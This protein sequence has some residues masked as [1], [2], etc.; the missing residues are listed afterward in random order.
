MRL[1]AHVPTRGRLASALRYAEQAGCEAIQIFVS[2]PRGWAP[3]VVTEESAGEFRSAA[4][5]ADIA[6]VFAHGS[7]LI[8]IASPDT[9]FWQRSVEL[10]RRELEAVSLVGGAGLVVHAGAGGPGERGQSLAR[11]AAATQAIAGAAPA[12]VVLELTAGGAGTVASTLPQAAELLDAVG[13]DDV[14][15]CVDTC[16][17]FAAGYALDRPDGVRAAFDELTRLG[18]DGRLRLVHANDAKDPRGSRRDRHEHV[19]MGHIG[20]EGFRAILAEPAVQRCAVLVETPG[21]VE[22]DIRNLAVLRRLA[23]D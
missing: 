8:N 18:L 12:E 7:Y 11:A 3:P 16:H 2:N 14:A 22:D 5:T 17:L 6:P 23:G 1:G 21:K 13:R 9:G 19:G 15:L 20:E 4:S 10:A